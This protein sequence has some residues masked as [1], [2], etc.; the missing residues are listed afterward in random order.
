M[1]PQNFFNIFL[2][3]ASLILMVLG[4][5]LL[6]RMPA[7]GQVTVVQA[8]LPDTTGEQQV[9]VILVN[10]Q[11]NT[12]QPFSVAMANDVVFNQMNAY[13][14]EASYQKAWLT[15]TVVGW[16][17]LPMTIGTSCPPTSQILNE[18]VKAADPNVNFNNY[19][20]IIV[21]FPG[22][23]VCY[24]GGVATLGKGT[25]NTN[26]GTISASTVWINSNYLIL[27]TIGHEFGHNLGLLHARDFDCG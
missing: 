23:S 7:Y 6:S 10:F 3:K 26:D 9:I 11:D 12:S 4:L 19:G 15:G 13:Y 14:S 8:P 22:I 1:N 17:T 5:L 21:M 16:Y 27:S 24:Y 20:R 18:A 2:S 25:V